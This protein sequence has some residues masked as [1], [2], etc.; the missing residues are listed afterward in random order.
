VQRRSVL[1]IREARDARFGQSERVATTG[2][3]S[4][5]WGARRPYRTGPWTWFCYVTG[6]LVA[7]FAVLFL[8]AGIFGDD[9]RS[10]GGG[11][12]TTAERVSV[13]ALALTLMPA[14]V[15]YFWRMARLGVYVSNA[16][17]QIRQFLR[18]EQLPWSWIDSFGTI[19]WSG[20][21][22]PT[23]VVHLTNGDR[24]VIELLNG[25]SPLVW[26][27]D[28]PPKIAARLNACRPPAT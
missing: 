3:V 22:S 18:S 1:A 15:Y 7:L 23:L 11:T 6:L 26:L 17:V 8:V 4:R 14:V 10:A 28:K 25:K 21:G 24:R 12:T 5:Q 20:A 9:A 16:G 2:A 19:P 13:V 27:A